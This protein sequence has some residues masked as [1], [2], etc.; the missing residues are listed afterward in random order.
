MKKKKN[1]II[2]KRIDNFSIVIKLIFITIISML[3]YT[4]IIK[5][6]YYRTILET[7]T[8]KVYE[9][10]D[11]PR[12]K[13]YD[14][15]HNLLVDNRLSPVISYLKP[16]GISVQKELEIARYLSNYLDIDYKKINNTILKYYYLAS[17]NTDN[18]ITDSEYRLLEERKITNKDIYNMK[19]ERIKESDIDYNDEEKETAYIYYLMNNDYSYNIK[20]IKKDNLTDKEISTI[21]DN[22]DNL[23]GVFIDYFYERNYLYGDTFRNILGSISNISFEDKDYY[24]EKGYKITD[25]VG[26][27]YIEK[28]YDE[29]LKGVKGTYKIVDNKIEKISDS[30]RGK[31]LVLTIDIKLQVELDKILESELI[32]TKSEANT[33]Y[34]NSIYVV[35]KDPKT[36]DILA[37]SGKK[38]KKSGNKY[39]VVDDT[40]GV[41]TYS[42][43][44]GSVVKGASM[45][46]GYNEGAIKMGEK[47]N[48]SCIKIYSFPKKC[49]WSKLGVIDDITALS[50]SSNIYQFKTAFKVA[51]FDYSY[52]A[53][54]K[55][56]NGAFSKYRTFFNSIGLGSKSEIDLPIDS[57][58][59]VGKSNS[60][61]LY[62][63]YVIGQYD[64]YT[65]MQLS[66]Y[67]STIANYGVRVFP[68]L[69]LEVRNNDNDDEL[70]SL[71]FKY[72]SKS[73][74]LPV[75]KKYIDRVRYGFK[76][77]MKTGLG[78]GFMGE[79]SNPS[80]KTGTSESFYDSDSDGVIDSPTLSNAFVGY[81]PSDKPKM[82]IAV[83]YP[84]LVSVND[85]SSRSY[86]NKRITKRISNLF[87]QL[88]Q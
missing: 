48:D 50:M 64:T 15:N 49:S 79:A 43:T 38:L 57:I 19:L 27:S 65:V 87:Y 82:S 62:L 7:K 22:K 68:H 5:N 74:T 77:V 11:A 42:M 71:Y 73:Y 84:N 10:L 25:L 85:N 32:K 41:L 44:P 16:S 59:N 58:G 29:Y 8:N 54:I 33:K 45:L 60:P 67:I 30:E 47:M 9:F 2:N 80:G 78:K 34:F 83:I 53:K 56:V 4:T 18:L 51:K 46:V 17:N 37:M 69:L 63:N 31:D 12:G 66:E 26:S 40:V 55:D 52:N 24:L 23:P 3:F 14:R 36:G 35:I 72:E 61:D 28:Q 88:Y 75:E 81:Y 70:G 39:E 13:I 1:A 86:A 20:K 6:N 76:E 21:L